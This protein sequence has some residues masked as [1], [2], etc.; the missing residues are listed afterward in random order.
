MKL[1]DLTN[2]FAA[3]I[4]AHENNKNRCKSTFNGIE[5]KHDPPPPSRIFDIRTPN[6]SY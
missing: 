6:K 4:F 3:G 1:I 5:F 2:D